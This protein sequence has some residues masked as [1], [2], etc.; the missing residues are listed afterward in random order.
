MNL[1]TRIMLVG[2]GMPIPAPG[3]QEWTSSGSYSFVVP[4]G[5]RNICAV[6]IGAGGG[7]ARGTTG[8]TVSVGAGGGG[9]LSYS[10]NIPVTPGETL[11]VFVGLKGSAGGTQDDGGNGGN[12]RILRGGTEILRA[13]GGFGGNWSSG[14]GGAGANTLGAIGDVKFSGGAGDDGNSSTAWGGKTANYTSNGAGASG[15][16]YG[17]RGTALNGIDTLGVIGG[18]GSSGTSGSA[19]AGEDGGAR[20]IWGYGRSYPSNALDV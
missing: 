4:T 19:A 5:V 18:G 1:I 15:V 6:C 14:D 2:A 16:D 10:N 13:N 12:T 9:G 20:I 3:Q 17:K 7:G 8:D 11:T